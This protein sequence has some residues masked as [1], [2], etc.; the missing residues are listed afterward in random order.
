M[1]FFIKLE[2]YV[3]ARLKIRNV[4][5]DIKGDA[6]MQLF[7]WEWFRSTTKTINQINSYQKQ[8]NF[9]KLDQ[10]DDSNVFQGLPHQR[11]APNQFHKVCFCCSL[12]QKKSN[13]HCE[14]T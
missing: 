12:I 10:K 3:K 9:E 11:Q 14:S 4:F 8:K 5:N 7:L 1:R 13:D 6:Q 2:M